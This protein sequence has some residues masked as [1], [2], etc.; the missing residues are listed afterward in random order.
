VRPLGRLREIR[1]NLRGE[2][3]KETQVAA[4]KRVVLV[5]DDDDAFRGLVRA[6]LERAGFHVVEAADG[7]TALTA[8]D[9]N[10]PHLALLDVVI[11]GM[12]GYELFEALRERLGD[13]LP[14]IFV[15]GVRTD[16]YD[17]VAGLLLGA[18]DYIVKPFDPD[19]L[20]ARVRRSLRPKGAR[21]VP[22]SKSHN[23][24][25]AS[26]T[27]RELEIVSLLAAGSST[28]EIAH[29]LVISPRT[30]GTH[31][32]HILGKLGVRNRG[33]AVALAFREGLV[34][35]EVEA[36]LVTTARASEAD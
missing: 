13:D 11:P 18:D 29:D 10:P 17:R 2:Y 15:S 27:P 5:V 28:E 35:A 7:D 25:V 22:A 33:Q 14:V 26:L 6:M 4:A 23:G 34:S 31:V 21:E 36:H 20:I 32:Q 3:E 1:Y 19:E 24:V 12:S 8:A 30:V 16:H 9:E